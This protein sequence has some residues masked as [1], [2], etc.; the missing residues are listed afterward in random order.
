MKKLF[1]LLAVV[2]LCNNLIAQIITVSG[3]VFDKKKN[4]PLQNITVAAGPL[5]TITDKD[6]KFILEADLTILINKGV[7]IS[8][9]GYFSQR[10]IY[11]PNHYYDI[12]LLEE[13]MQLQP[14]VI[15]DVQSIIKRAYLNIPKNYPEQPTLI[16]GILRTESIRNNSN[17]FNSDAILKAYVPPYTLSK[18]E[19][20][21]VI[22]VQ[23]KID[24]IIDKSLPNYLIEVEDYNI[25]NQYDF[26]HSQKLLKRMLLKSNFFYTVTGKQLFNNRKVYVINGVLKDSIKNKKNI[27]VVLYIDTATYA[28]AA[29]NVDQYNIK[30]LGFVD[31]DK[32]SYN[33]VYHLNGHKWHLAEI[34]LNQ[35]FYFK[36]EFP[37]G[38]EVFIVTKTENAKSNA[39][40]YKDIVQEHDDVEKI[41]KPGD[42]DTWER[43]DSLFTR[44]ENEGRMFTRSPSMLDTIKQNS[45]NAKLEQTDSI[46]KKIARSDAITNYILNDG[47]KSIIAL[48]HFPFNIS[49]QSSN[50]S[51][52]ANLGYT[53][54]ISFKIYKTFYL[55]F[56]RSDNLWNSKHVDMLQHTYSLSNDFTYNKNHHPITV[57]PYVSGEFI[58]ISYKSNKVNY[59]NL[60][61]G[62]FNEYELTHSK[63]L[64]L[65]IGYN[66]ASYTKNIN[67]L[68]ILPIHINTTIGLRY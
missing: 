16:T 22:V 62:L 28:F 15:Y 51:Y 33:V 58:T 56:F 27:D 35:K 67:E 49:S 37:T 24:T 26:V 64:F 48:D 31:V 36:K 17:Y 29:V 5:G 59:N 23:N 55:G 21:A 39:F 46:R 11:Q 63:K 25:V 45:L 66:T 47:L 9:V 44:A 42:I 38:K 12:E 54:G 57:S 30:R 41:S 8:A 14:V 32:E 4:S 52:S 3:M 18:N 68:N 50:I 13:K 61:F 40:S 1:L 10:L 60:G 20:T 34:V 65:G 6:G 2:L 43:Y 19:K 53:L 7:K